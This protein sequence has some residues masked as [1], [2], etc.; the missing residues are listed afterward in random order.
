MQKKEVAACFP[1]TYQEKKVLY[2]AVHH[3]FFGQSVNL[4]ANFSLDVFFF[5]H[6]LT[7]P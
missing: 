2:F 1:N 7:L 4:N 3:D 5:Y 6:E